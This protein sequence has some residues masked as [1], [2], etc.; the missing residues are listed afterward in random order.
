MTII[1]LLQANWPAIAVALVLG[2]F[3]VWWLLRRRAV[4]RERYRAPDALDEGATPAPRNQALIDAPT[5]VAH[6]TAAVAVPSALE[7]DPSCLKQ[8]GT[9]DSLFP[10][11]SESPDEPIWLEKALSHGGDDLAR[12]KGVGPKLVARLAELGVNSY[13]EIAAWDAADLAR[14]DGQLGIFAGRPLRDNWVEQAH[15]LASGDVTGYEA[16]FGKL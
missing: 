14:I 5:A 11:F 10:A 8:D 9:L 4:P 13:A 1:H 7:S 15:F 6:L 12:I 3:A 16:K 2:L